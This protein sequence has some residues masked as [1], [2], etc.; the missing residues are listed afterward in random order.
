M[1]R[2]N[3]KLSRPR[4]KRRMFSCY[5]AREIAF[6]FLSFLHWKAQK[7]AKLSDE[8][9]SESVNVNDDYRSD[10]VERLSG[11]SKTHTTLTKKNSIRR[12]KLCLYILMKERRY[13]MKLSGILS[14]P[15]AS[16]PAEIERDRLHLAPSL[17]VIKEKSSWRQFRSLLMI[18]WMQF[19]LLCWSYFAF[20]MTCWRSN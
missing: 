10:L 9:S 8:Q 19:M 17:H 7:P 16:L 2:I 12:T 18:V 15:L 13:S 6:C 1:T 11:W 14:H 5:S 3:S 20:F 4:R